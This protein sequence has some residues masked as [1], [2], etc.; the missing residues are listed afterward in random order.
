MREVWK[1]VG[2]LGVNFVVY[3]LLGGF[4]LRGLGGRKSRFCKCYWEWEDIV[5][6][7]IIYFF[8]Y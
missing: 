5:Y 4:Y 6:G 1:E 2:L 7:F 8:V 3:S